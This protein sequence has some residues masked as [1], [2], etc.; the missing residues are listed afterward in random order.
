MAKKFFKAAW[1]GNFTKEANLALTAEGVWSGPVAVGDFNADGQQDVLIFYFE[2]H[3]GEQL[4]EP[5]Q[6]RA[7][8]LLGDG[9]GNF[10]DGTASMPDGGSFNYAIRKLAVG[11]FNGDGQ[12]DVAMVTNYED[13]RD[14]TEPQ[15]NAAPQ[16]LL[17]SDN[18]HLSLVEDRK[19]VV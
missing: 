8:L 12:D 9:E 16:V 15:T 6:G 10:A 19:S 13:G 7:V 18:G 3:I 5:T 1:S 11:D 4:S 2:E 17:V 14:T